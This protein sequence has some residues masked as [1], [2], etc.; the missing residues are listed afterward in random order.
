MQKRFYCSPVLNPSDISRRH[1]SAPEPWKVCLPPPPA[2]RKVGSLL[3]LAPRSPACFSLCRQW[4]CPHLP[5]CLKTQGGCH[6]GDVTLNPLQRPTYVW[7]W[8]VPR[9]S[10][11]TP[12]QRKSR[13]RL[14]SPPA[15]WLSASCITLLIKPGYDLQLFTCLT[16]DLEIPRCKGMCIIH[17]HQ[18]S[19]CK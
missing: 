5:G 14:P 3:S 1:P 4:C 18:A 8:S 11:A 6:L 19:L 9:P 17:P 16:V 15:Y 7:S 12:Q 10:F 2:G 13:G